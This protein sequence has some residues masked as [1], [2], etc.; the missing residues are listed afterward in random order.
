MRA[1]LKTIRTRMRRNSMHNNLRPT[2]PRLI[3]S[4]PAG[5]SLFSPALLSPSIIRPI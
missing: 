5:A 3:R 1:N 4:A 2:M